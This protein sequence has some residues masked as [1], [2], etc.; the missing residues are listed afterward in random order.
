ML[1]RR[2][3]EVRRRLERRPL[4]FLVVVKW[5]RKLFAFQLTWRSVLWPC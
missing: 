5:C 2:R 3:G 1:W 4:A